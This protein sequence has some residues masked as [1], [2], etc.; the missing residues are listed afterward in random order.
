MLESARRWTGY[1]CPHCRFVF[2][3]PRDHDGQGAVCPSC[4]RILKIPTAADISPPL[5]TPSRRVSGDGVVPDAG[6][7]VLKKRRRG[8]KLDPSD[9]PAW[10]QGPKSVHASKRD[11]G[12]MRQILVGGAVLFA[13]IIAGV[14]FSM[15]A[16]ER[17]P[18]PP[19]KD[20]PA[21]PAAAETVAPVTGERSEAAIL[22][23]AEPLAREFLEAKT[24]AQ[25]LPLVRHPEVTELR[26][27]EV[28]PAGK[29][30]A[31]GLSKFNSS[32]GISVRKPF[33]SLMVRTREQLEKPLAF[34]ETPQGLK[35]D[36]ESWE[37]WSAMSWEKFLSTKPRTAQVFRVTLSAVNYY[38]FNFS[39]DS[40]WQSYRLISPDEQHSL[41]GYV[42]KG[43][44]LDQK[45]SPT[46]EVKAAP[47]MLSIK[48]PTEVV[49]D[50]QVEIEGFV[51]EGWVED[52]SK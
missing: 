25:L 11:S 1:V 39:D 20:L 33:V 12:Q 24:V 8:R 22:A 31:P 17:T 7:Q 13:A 40:K 10:E 47:L 41:Y 3:V 51:A 38:N 18:V 5:T 9:G 14:F 37:G 30:E 52:D 44:A 2:R 21:L 16:G 50:S 4:S 45:I 49:S 19:H 23:E 6:P 48:Y 27:R 34:I 29:I 36:W 32:E 35:I 28:Y 26:M 15:R 43:S 46:E 42:E